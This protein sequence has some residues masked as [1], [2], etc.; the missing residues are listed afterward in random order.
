MKGGSKIE[1]L[2]NLKEVE[3][4]ALACITCGQCRNPIWPSKDRFGVCP[5]YSTDFTPKFEAFYARGKNIIIRGLL[6]G[7]LPL[8]FDI[9]NVFFQCTN[10]GSCE[11]FCHNSYNKNIRFLN[12]KW[13]ENVKVYEALRADL[14]EA[15]VK[16]VGVFF[17]IE[18]KRPGQS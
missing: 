18:N 5:I 13:I 4:P 1:K 9:A 15:G 10:C 8:S 17:V 12:H 11:E 6:W 3:V 14:V 2:K 7:D 16:E